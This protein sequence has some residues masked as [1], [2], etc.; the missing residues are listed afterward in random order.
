MNAVRSKPQH[1]AACRAPG[2][3][4]WATHAGQHVKPLS[5]A[6][7][8]YM[9]GR[10]VGSALVAGLRFMPSLEQGR[11]V[12]HAWKYP[13]DLFFPDRRGR[14]QDAAVDRAKLCCSKCPVRMECAEAAFSV[15]LRVDGVWAGSLPWDR[16][17]VHDEMP[18]AEAGEKARRLIEIVDEQPRFGR[19]KDG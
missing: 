4:G 11:C 18:D 2:C 16:A 17:R 13:P 3:L 6:D 8:S 5:R 14:H 19:R 1:V 12:T 15:R 9:A 7:V 10:L